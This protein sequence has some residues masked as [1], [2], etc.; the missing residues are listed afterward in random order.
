MFKFRF[1]AKVQR[2]LMDTLTRIEKGSLFTALLGAMKADAM[3][4]AIVGVVVFIVCRLLSAFV[5]GIE[6]HP[7][8]PKRKKKPRSTDDDQDGS[9]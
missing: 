2:N 6:V 9:A 5:A 8:S 3:T 7:E 4:V 1:T